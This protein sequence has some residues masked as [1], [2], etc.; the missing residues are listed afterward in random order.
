MI[1]ILPYYQ[2]LEKQVD[3]EKVISDYGKPLH[4]RDF[5]DGYYIFT[6]SG[7]DAIRMIMEYERL[8]RWDEV[9]IT[10][11]TDSPFVS[12][13]VSATI[14]NYSKISRVLTENTKM[15]FVIHSFGFAHPR[16]EELRALATKRNLVLVEDCAFAVDSCNENG[17][18]LGS[19]GDYAI[20]SL[21][22]ILPMKMGGI[23][24]F[25]KRIDYFLHQNDPSIEEEADRLFCLLD[26]IK[27]RRR[28]N[29]EYLENK[30]NFETIY[31][32]TFLT[33]PFMFGFKTEK[34]DY[35]IKKCSQI[36]EFGR[37][38]VKNEVH[39]PLNP[40]IDFKDYDMLIEK[41]EEI[42]HA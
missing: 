22:K 35:I 27:K 2:L 25:K 26:F 10:T 28:E 17:L 9:Y 38:H 19:L 37:T 41:I 29:Y 40:F 12:T 39:I 13:C 5:I 4:I 23:L 42:V 18:R 20:Y 15:I 7:R 36:C 30:L 31:K 6:K 21:S 14:F 8:T 1:R 32:N 33:N 34:Y 3:I 11:T 16:I 24:A